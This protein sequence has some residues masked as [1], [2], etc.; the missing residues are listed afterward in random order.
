V[1]AVAVQVG[2]PASVHLDVVEDH[3][4]GARPGSAVTSAVDVN[5]DVRCQTELLDLAGDDS[6]RARTS[7]AVA[8][9]VFRRPRLIH[10][11]AIVAANNTN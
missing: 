4:R 8:C 7:S 1:G 9:A 10:L 2:R 11:Q 5:A 3:S 6:S